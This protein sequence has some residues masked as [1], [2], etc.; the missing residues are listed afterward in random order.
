MS[1]TS[2]QIDAPPEDVF[3]V[4]SDPRAYGYF[5]VGTRKVR[6][7]DPE[8]PAVGSTLHHTAG[9]GPLAI[10]D[11]STVVEAEPPL[12]LLIEARFRPL[13]VARIRLSLAHAGAG[14]ELRIEESPVSG[15]I[16]LPVIRT[17]AAGA[18]LVR[19]RELL[20][21]VRQLALRRVRQRDYGQ[22]A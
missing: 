4:L 13:G 3:A 10:R 18:F 15:P 11:S 22:A 2:T 8:W 20:R 9:I 5:V 17:V 21:R 19:N 7:F 12:S 1:T 14:T 6:R 16:G